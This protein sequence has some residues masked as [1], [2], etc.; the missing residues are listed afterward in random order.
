[1]VAVID[2]IIGAFRRKLAIGLGARRGIRRLRV[3]Y[4]TYSQEEML[5]GFHSLHV[6]L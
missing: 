5:F 4:I 1:M 6:L 3:T 2:A